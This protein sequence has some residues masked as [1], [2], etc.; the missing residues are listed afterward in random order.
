MLTGNLFELVFDGQSH[1]TRKAL[2]SDARLAFVG[3]APQAGFAAVGEWALDDPGLANP[4]LSEAERRAVLREYAQELSAGSGS[5]NENAY[6][7]SVAVADVQVGPGIAWPFAAPGAGSFHARRPAAAL[8]S[9][10]SPLVVWTALSATTSTLRWGEFEQG[11]L[12]E[13]GGIGAPDIPANSVRVA[14]LANGGAIAVWTQGAIGQERVRWAS[15]DATTRNWSSPSAVTHTG[16]PQWWPALA[17]AGDRFAVAWLDLSDRWGAIRVATGTVA[18]GLTTPVRVDGKEPGALKGPRN[19]AFAP[20]VA[21]NEHLLLVAWTDFRDFSWDVY[22]AVSTDAGATFTEPRRVDHAGSNAERIHRGVVAALDADGVMW[23]AWTD[24]RDRRADSDVVVAF[25]TDGET[26]QEVNVSPP[27][28]S[29]EA[30]PSLA[31]AGGRTWV[32]FQSTFEDATQI[33]VT[34]G[35][36]TGAFRPA[37]AADPERSPMSHAWAPALASGAAETP[38]LVWE[39]G[40]SG[41]S[42]VRAQLNLAP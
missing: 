7:E 36:Q 17:T 33:F 18:D 15:F 9:G 42:T 12:V 1:I 29:S 16:G 19:G 3:N 4:L 24:M 31:I 38:L 11:T 13:R 21:M 25:S 23:L 22:A 27:G 39:D 32:A 6:V 5:A 41:W 10:V 40:R 14:P 34:S 30:E 26:W 37:E 2:P 20:A 8:L 35:L 28:P